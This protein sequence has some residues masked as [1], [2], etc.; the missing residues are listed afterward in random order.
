MGGKSS[1]SSQT[2]QQVDSR[3]VNT[4]TDYNTWNTSTTNNLDYKVDNSVDLGSGAI[5]ATNGGTVIQTDGGAIRGALDLADNL[6]SQAFKTTAGTV[7]DAFSFGSDLASYF[8]KAINANSGRAFDSVDNAVTGLGSVASKAFN[9]ADT[10]QANAFDFG[11]TLAKL[12]GSQ[13]NTSA[14]RALDSVDNATAAAIGATS[15]ATASAFDLVDSLGARETSFL[16]GVM[17]QQNEATKGIT[18]LVANAYNDAK[19]RGAMTDTLML[20]AIGGAVA[21]AIFAL[22]RR[23]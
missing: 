13:V 19:G 10:S 11:Q 9:F 3:Q 22:Q 2:T 16:R 18:Q 7:S 14:G 12:F 23:G 6:S 20:V 15:K 17:D 1:N 8:G 4:R 21:V 5:F